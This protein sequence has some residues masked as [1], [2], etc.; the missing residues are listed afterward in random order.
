MND[1]SYFLRTN[2]HGS[3]TDGKICKLTP[4]RKRFERFGE[5]EIVD[6]TK[7]FRLDFVKKN[8]ESGFRHITLEMGAVLRRKMELASF[9]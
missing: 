6:E 7:S 1:A 9:I 2:V 3:I 8:T 4:I 5:V